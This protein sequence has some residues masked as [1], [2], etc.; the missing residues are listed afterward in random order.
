[1][2]IMIDG[3]RV[4]DPTFDQGPTGP[5]FPID[6]DMIER[7]EYIP[8]PGGAVYGQNAT[9]GVINVITRTGAEL[10]SSGRGGAE[11][12]A[13]YEIPQALSAGRA[14]V[15]HVFDNGLNVLVSATDRIH[16]ARIAITTSARPAYPG[17]RSAWTASTTNS[18]WRASPA[19]HGLSSRCTPIT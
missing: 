2:L 5:E 9:L 6:M 18:S 10:G 11:L 4:N 16:A 8:G 19:A 7:I 1:V 17:W 15:G 3:N 14:S 12:A 13:T